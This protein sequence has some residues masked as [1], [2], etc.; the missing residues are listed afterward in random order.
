[1]HLALLDSISP[2]VACAVCRGAE[3]DTATIAA[4]LAIGFMLVVVAGVLGSVLSFVFYLGRKG[5]EAAIHEQNSE[6]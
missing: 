6:L 4:N 3:G 1:M 5:R 2:T